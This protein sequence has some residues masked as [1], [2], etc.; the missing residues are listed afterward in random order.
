VLLLSIHPHLARLILQG[1]KT[2]ELRRRAPRRPPEFW[3]ALYAT[4]PMRAL[5]G[6]VKASE[7]LVDQPDDLWERVKDGCGLEGEA[8]RSYF[9]GANRAIGIRLAGPI[10]FE[11]P[12]RLESLRSAWRGFRPPRSYSYLSQDRAE[13]VWDY[14]RTERQA[15]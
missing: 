13:E 9:A 11:R 14:T 15:V 5:V 1:E 10:P 8:Y 12:W 2:I 3:I 7:I 6:L 4:A